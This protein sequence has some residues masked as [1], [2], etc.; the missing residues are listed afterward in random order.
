MQEKG[1]GHQLVCPYKMDNTQSASLIIMFWNCSSGKPSLTL[2]FDKFEHSERKE[3]NNLP[4]INMLKQEWQDDYFV[5][6][7]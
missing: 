2:D 5:R 4:S 3:E 1:K 6:P 7:R